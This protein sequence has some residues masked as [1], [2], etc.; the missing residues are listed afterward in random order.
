MTSFKLILRS[1]THHW[2]INLAVALGVAAA[3]AVLTGALLVG[4]SV[5]GSLRALTLDRL[6]AID[7]VLI[8][9]RFF[10]GE[11]VDELRDSEAFRQ[12]YDRAAA[13]II[14]PSATVER[15]GGGAAARA[16]GV[17]VV[18][19][20]ADFW[21]LD[22]SGVRL[23][24]HP[25]PDEIVLNEVVA[26]QW[27][28]QVG[29]EVVL[30]LPK[31]NQVPADSP[32]AQKA[33]RIRTLA[34]LTVVDIIPARGLGRFSL[35][36][37]QQL[38]QNVFVSLDIL[39]E[40][41][42]QS[43]RVNAVL[44]AG[45]GEA[46]PAANATEGLQNAL[47]PTLAD[48][49]ISVSRV[50]RTFTPLEGD[51]EVVF[52]YF[53]VTTDRMI[54]SDEAEAAIFK[55]I[56][57]IGG[58]GLSTYLAN[59]IA[60]TGDEAEAAGIP[61]STITAINPSTSFPLSDRS[62]RRIETLAD[63]EIVLTNWAADDLQAEPGDILRIEYF[64]PE[65]TH[66]DAMEEN[67]QFVVK[68]ITPLTEPAQSY[69]R[70]R[71]ATYEQRPTLVNDPS[72]TPTVDGVTDQE[73]I[74]NWDPPFP[75]DNQRV[76]DED[77][78]YWKNHRTTPKAFVSL[79][80]GER[81]W[82]SRFGR[83]TGFRVP[84]DQIGE[85]NLEE[86]IRQQLARDGVRM[87]LDIV[88]V[89]R[90]QLQSSGGTTPFDGLFLALSFFII[91]AALMLVFLLFRLGVEQRASEVGTMLAEGLSRRLV[92]RML[93][94]EGSLVAL[95]GGL[96]GLLVGVGYAQLMLAG[97]TT[98]WL[99][100][101]V[102]PFLEYHWTWRSI[103]IGYLAGVAI[104]ALTIGWSVRRLR[105]IAVRRLLAGQA[106]DSS[107][108]RVRAHRRIPIVGAGLIVVAMILSWTA[109]RLVGMLQAG[110]FFGAGATLL[111]ALL[112]FVWMRLAWS[113]A[114][115]PLLAPAALAKLAWRNAARNPSRSAIT[116]SLMAT[117]SFL[118]VAMSSFR[119]QPTSA[120]TGGFD[121][122]AQSALPVFADLN[123]TEGRKE[124]LIDRAD[125]LSGARA[126]G[127]RL[128]DGDDASCNN[129]YRS[130]QPRILGVT[131]DFVSYF[132]GHTPARFRWSS[133]D[134]Q[135]AEEKSNPWRM[136]QRAVVDGQDVPAVI[137]MNTAMYSL[138]LPPGTGSVFKAEYDD[139]TVRFRV[140]GLLDN[141][142]LQGSILVGE[143]H[144]EDLF[145]DVG[146]Y[147]YFMIR[148]PEGKQAD[149][150][151]VLEDRLGDWGFDAVPADQVL[152]QL[153]A[154]QNTYLSTF[155]SLGALGLLLGTF[156]LATVQL[157]N[158]VE[159]RGELALMRAAGFR[160]RRLTQI[161]LIENVLLLVAGL[162]TG[163]LAAMLVVL[164]HKLTGEAAISAS[165][166]R[167]LLLM[168][169][170]VLVVGVLASVF[171]ARAV[172]RT[173]LLPALR[174][175]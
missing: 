43:E 25:G 89:K 29:D 39:Q 129:L 138:G 75:F 100:A 59:R 28:A 107:T 114:S 170:A 110:A 140:V 163:S 62:G 101:I 4:D 148:S 35:R 90:R 84:T 93:I 99:G 169:A 42:D 82:G 18:G 80:A 165:L 91:A 150:Q 10:R 32:L 121:L 69:R 94:A 24:K 154:V 61:Y 72:L 151:S 106:T 65:T 7:E 34:G 31:G 23:E 139:R 51:E 12:S 108:F 111:T 118:I 158:I 149:V 155:Q 55:A 113:G 37:S 161:V 132:D 153:L 73:S 124:A 83:L 125:V 46:P 98:W 116:I 27:D 21:E 92:S 95:H 135:T 122:L 173:P 44:I 146:G 119:M 16:A 137:D 123:S 48:L 175:D 127:L 85:A 70:R 15:Q 57:P 174:G 142:V 157:R 160:H 104:S 120:G 134:P 45:Q 8:S 128:R 66:G 105:R 164:P 147:R 141:S 131:P 126:F 6:G 19:A 47:Q 30:R 13:A 77:D 112:L 171:T 1:L 11:L 97:L 103:A 145:S 56:E 63:D 26:R 54:L 33:D 68:A 74:A 144:F 109:T 159:R 115:R 87:G 168:L 5:R 17:L 133:A 88:P 41:L 78:A 81:L 3:T 49:G 156:G 76:R 130:Q 143:S 71:E 102:T 20:D 22:N 50:R 136:L 96:L 117:A 172:L 52:D 167:D 152:G 36:A 67:A 86:L 14:F 166:L 38:P 58:Q 79:A 53:S 40:A 60:K 64:A 162:G 9:D 2:R